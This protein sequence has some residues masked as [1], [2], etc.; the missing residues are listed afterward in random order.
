MGIPEYQLVIF[1]GVM[2]ATAALGQVGLW[3]ACGA[4]AQAQREQAEAAQEAAAAR[5]RVLAEADAQRAEAEAAAAEKRKTTAREKRLLEWFGGVCWAVAVFGYWFD[6]FVKSRSRSL[7]VE[8]PAICRPFL[9][10]LLRVAATGNRL[11]RI[12]LAASLALAVSFSAWADFTGKV[13][14]VADGDSIT[15]LRD[16]EQVKVR[17]VEIDAPE[18][19]QPFG[20]RSKQALEA[21]VKGQEVRVVERGK[22]R[23]QRTLGRIYRGD[24]DVNAEQVRQGMAW[25]FR[26][27][28]KDATLY[29]I[30]AEAKEQKR[31][32]WRDPE[33]VPPWE[34]RKA[35]SR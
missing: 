25:V 11:F 34:W 18:A 31:G 21:L 8:S 6:W 23:Y 27:Y 2:L 1:F 20:N 4:A 13:V 32:L 17:L 15:V 16:R 28:A 26:Q 29:P 24:L 9:D 30:E 35:H 10:G 22:D 19:A 7:R 3:I 14:N 12:A 33:P 5:R